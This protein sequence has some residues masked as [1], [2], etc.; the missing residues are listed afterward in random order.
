MKITLRFTST[1]FFNLIINIFLSLVPPQIPCPPPEKVITVPGE[2]LPPPPRKVVIE[3]LPE[4]P[5]KPQDVT[6]ILIYDLNMF[7]KLINS[8]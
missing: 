3:R 2:L 1:I 7:K 6:F 8:N 4:L 5:D